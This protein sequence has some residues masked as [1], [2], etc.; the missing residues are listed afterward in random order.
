LW[1]VKREEA[2]R[3]PAR[4]FEVIPRILPKLRSGLALLGH[5]SGETDNFFQALE[6]LHRP[7]LKLRAKHRRQAFQ[8]EP[9][10]TQEQEDDLRPAPAQ[11]PRAREELWLRDGELRACGFEDTLP[12]DYGGLEPSS[13]AGAATPA[14]VGNA[15]TVQPIPVVTVAG[16]P[17]SPSQAD[18]LIASLEEG[19]WVDLFSKQ[20]WRRA[21][22]TWASTQGTLF[23][24]VSHGGRPHSMTKRSLQR[25]VINRLLR[26]VD[27]REVVQ[28]ALDALARPVSEPLAA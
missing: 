25:L 4:A 6:R 23:M 14:P 18:A 22:L 11:K 20:R 12:S 21:R 24:F 7:V 3:D 26:P 9:A 8:A 1:S 5:Q 15:G 10:P 2:L 13:P 16:V 19:C 28:H 17:L 27:S